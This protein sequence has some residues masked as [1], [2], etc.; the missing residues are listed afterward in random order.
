[1]RLGKVAAWSVALILGLFVCLLAAG[2]AWWLRERSQA[3]SVSAVGSPGVPLVSSGTPSPA[4]TTESGPFLGLE[5]G[6]SAQ[7]IGHPDQPTAAADLRQEVAQVNDGSAQAPSPEK[8]EEVERDYT[9][10]LKAPSSLGFHPNESL[11]RDVYFSIRRSFVEPVTDEDLFEGIVKEVRILLVQ[12]HVPTDGLQRLDHNRNVLTQLVSLYG[13]KVPKDVLVY[14]AIQGMLLGLEDPYSVLMAPEEYGKLQESVQNKEFGG[15]G[16]YIELDK[17]AGNQLTV[18]EPIE[19]TPAARSG[20]ESGDRIVAIDGKSTKGITLDGAQASIR[21]PVGSRVVLKVQR[22]GRSAPLDIAIT[23]ANIHVVSVTGKM[24][25]D[26][27]GYLRMRQFGTL[28]A[29][30]LETEM[31]KLRAQGARALILD[32]RNN[33]G[34]YIDAAVNVVGQFTQPGSLVVYTMNREKERRDYRSSTRGGVGLPLVVM[35]NRYS[36]SA[37][38]ITAGALRDHKV[39]ALVGEKSYGKGSVQQL[40]PFSDNSALK[41]T[42]ARFYSPAGHV[43]DHKGLVPEHAVTMEPRFVGKMDK[44]VQLQKAIRVL[45]T[46]LGS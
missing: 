45:R 22:K 5:P 33:G 12:A 36:A 46:E 40:Y 14:A 23:R 17:D 6:V 2:G 41:L 25:P 38:E 21:G 37:S 18:F 43:I 13:Q 10:L 39:A 15:I 4:P 24:L 26:R 3:G 20:V 42:I 29:S 16:I 9:A 35:I 30:E 7:P 8:K 32:L 44:D 31:G 27:I 28:T 19:G 34:G 1:M 11:F